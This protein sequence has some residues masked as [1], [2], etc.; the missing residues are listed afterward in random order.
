MKKRV[1]GFIIAIAVV[2]GVLAPMPITFAASGNELV[3]VTAKGKT[4]TGKFSGTFKYA[5]P[6]AQDT[7]PKQRDFSEKYYYD[8]SYFAVP[9][10]QYNVQ[11]ATMSLC[12]ELSAWNSNESG[13]DAYSN[14]EDDY[15][16]K[17]VNAQNLLK[18]MGFSGIAVNKWFTQ[19]PEM[20]S[21]GVIAGSKEVKYDGA[22]YTLIAVAIRG[23]NYESEWASNLTLGKQGDHQGFS[24]AKTNVLEFLKAYVSRYGISGNIKVWLTGYSRGGAVANLVGAALNDSFKLGNVTLGK[25]NTY[26][27]TFEAPKGTVSENAKSASYNN[28]FNILNYN[29]LVPYVT[30]EGWGFKRYGND[31]FMP[32]T[33]TYG[34]YKENLEYYSKF[35]SYPQ[36]KVP[37]L[38][39]FKRI[40]FEI[41][42]DGK[43][44]N[45]SLPST[46]K[47]YKLQP[48]F[49]KDISA[50]LANDVFV[51]RASYAESNQKSMRYLLSVLNTGV[52]TGKVKDIF[53][54]KLGE[55][56]ISIIA[57]L[58]GE[59]RIADLT[60]IVAKC[61]SDSWKEAGLTAPS[62]YDVTSIASTAAEILG[63][64]VGSGMID[65][66]GTLLLNLPQIQE[67]HLP[68]LCMS[69]LMA[70]DSNYGQGNKV[71]ERTDSKHRVLRI[72]GTADVEAYDG[73]GKLVLQIKDGALKDVGGIAVHVDGDEK[74]AYFPPNVAYS[75]KVI[76]K[77]DSSMTY[78]VSEE[79]FTGGVPP[80]AVVYNQLKLAKGST[81]TGTLPAYSSKDY[82]LED[83]GTS[84]SYTLADSAGKAIKPTYDGGVE[85][86][87]FSIKAE[88]SN[89]SVGTTMGT[90]SYYMGQK[91]TVVALCVN[92]SS[93][94]GWYENGK[95]I[96][97]ANLAYTF[98]VQ[99]NR[100]LTAR[101]TASSSSVSEKSDSTTIEISLDDV[102][103]GI[104]KI[105]PVVDTISDLL[106]QQKEK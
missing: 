76:A 33:I 89:T 86:I 15:T 74:I 6:L 70:Q 19:K 57:A 106:K 103:N 42:A 14:G 102:V 18:G 20:D 58:S 54:K 8:D 71:F 3:E 12:Y 36:S 27:Y 47:D 17:S 49:V 1:V 32:D 21:I 50:G 30:M 48:Q 77:Q 16:N 95:K 24:E 7:E 63:G 65:E 84:L 56:A 97:G 73:K 83:K 92:D 2:V 96:E 11:L 52:T 9:S 72:N 85:G 37:S 61:L 81:Y 105:K 26:V 45:K 64:F 60:S 100:N 98:N 88:S 41:S 90:K 43:L 10:S 4:S 79:D 82:K 104:K 80:R 87:S 22:G 62:G 67:A 13:R 68:E 35:Q 66:L 93:F 44:T 28:I 78:M 94:D 23:G 69:W 53:V 99:G 34:D 59:D 55:K 46:S 101:F 31:I 51:S 29:D 5:S 25:D 75:V 91:A 38:A 40:A 39:P